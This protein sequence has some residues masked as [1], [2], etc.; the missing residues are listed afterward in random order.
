MRPAITNDWFDSD[1]GEIYRQVAICRVSET[2]DKHQFVFNPDMIL[3]LM[4]LLSS[5]RFSALFAS[6][7]FLFEFF[8]LFRGQIPGCG[9]AALS[10]CGFFFEF[11]EFFLAFFSA[12]SALFA[13][14]RLKQNRWNRRGA[15]NA[16]NS[17][18]TQR[19]FSICRIAD[20]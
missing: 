10:L 15:K 8:T 4:I 11:F 20:F 18:D 7:R 6:L 2:T 16:E 17:T 13:S 19:R 14:L 1:T 12:F 3:P 9:S 5:L